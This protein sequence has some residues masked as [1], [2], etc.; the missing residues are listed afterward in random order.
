MK[1]LRESRESRFMNALTQVFHFQFVGSH[2]FKAV[3]G[4]VTTENLT[5]S[6]TLLMVQSILELAALIFFTLATEVEPF[7]LLLKKG[8]DFYT[9]PS[10]AQQ[11]SSPFL[12]FF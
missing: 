4:L 11:S 2:S 12:V 5:F 1:G 7:S 3:N 6:G 8:S 9:S 10:M